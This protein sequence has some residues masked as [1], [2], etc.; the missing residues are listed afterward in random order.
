MTFPLAYT[1]LYHSIA[2]AEVSSDFPEAQ[3]ESFS[4]A[5]V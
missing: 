3:E 2:E 4:E 5:K 1:W